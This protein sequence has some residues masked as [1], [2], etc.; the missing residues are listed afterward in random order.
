M[1]TSE[2]KEL[3]PK[4]TVFSI[5]NGGDHRKQPR[6]GAGRAISFGDGISKGCVD[7]YV[8]CCVFLLNRTPVVVVCE[9]GDDV[10]GD[11]IDVDDDGTRDFSV[12]I[13]E[14]ADSSGAKRFAICSGATPLLRVMRGE[15]C[16]EDDC[17]L[18]C[19][20]VVAIAIG[21]MGVDVEE[22]GVEE[23]D[24]D[25]VVDRCPLGTE[26][27]RLFGPAGLTSLFSVH[28]YNYERSVLVLHT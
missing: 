12:E 9:G 25:F 3:T 21:M 10:G 6:A 22:V 14:S 4:G 7:V 17:D 8:R 2:R 19:C 1:G 20:D 23:C 18:G 11:G 5:L 13:A 24:F 27:L 15:G 16:E 26:P 28:W